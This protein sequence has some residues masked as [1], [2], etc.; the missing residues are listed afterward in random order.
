MQASLVHSVGVPEAEVLVVVVAF[1]VASVAAIEA[2][3]VVGIP[4]G[5]VVTSPARTCMQ[6]TPGLILVMAGSAWIT[7]EEDMLVVLAAV[8]TW[9]VVAAAAATNTNPVNKSW[10]AM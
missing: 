5:P 2:S 3:A 7:M 10:F 4:T 8:T 6:T 9:V 1:A